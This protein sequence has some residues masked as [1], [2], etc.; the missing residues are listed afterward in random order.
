MLLN[1]LLIIFY[2]LEN[3]E[4]VGYVNRYFYSCTDYYD[5]F[6]SA[7]YDMP[8]ISKMTPE[9]LTAIGIKKPNHRKK[10]KA[11]IVKLNIPDG[12]PNYIPATLDE[13][14]ILVRLHDYR[15]LLATQG[16]LNIDDLVQISIEDLEDIGIYRLGHQKRLL[17]SIKR[18]KDLKS[19]RRIAQYPSSASTAAATSNQNGVPTVR[20]LQPPPRLPPAAQ[21]QLVS[22]YYHYYFV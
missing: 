7:G 17:L 10:L 2:I 6:A 15:G 3:C 19:G 5:L 1:Y 21:Q 22:Y 13:F 8:T 20:Q 14:L 4:F 16:Y 12:L 18:A 9:D 11:E